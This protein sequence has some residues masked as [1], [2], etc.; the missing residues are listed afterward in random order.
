MKGINTRARKPIA[1]DVRM[2]INAFSQGKARKNAGHC[3]YR[4]QNMR[5]TFR[6]K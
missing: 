5:K 6:R 2:P 3:T 1:P 4:Y